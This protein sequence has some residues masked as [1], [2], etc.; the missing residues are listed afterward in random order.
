MQKIYKNKKR[1]GQNFL[2][3]KK[4][5][6]NIVNSIAIKKNDNMVEIGI[7]LGAITIPILE[8]IDILNIIEIDTDL[9]THWQK[10]QINNL[11]IHQ[12]D[13]LKFDF[14][15][16]GKDLRVVGNL[17]YNISTPILFKMLEN[18]DSIKDMLF[19]LQKEMVDRIVATNGN[20]TYG[21]ITVML[22]AFFD[23]QM[24]F[25]VP[26]FAFDPEPK[27]TSA[28]IYL[29][30]KKTKV[31]NIKN[32]EK[33]VKAAFSTRRKTLNNCLKK[34]ILQNDTK[35][36]LS[37]RAENLKIDDFII[38]SEDYGRLCNR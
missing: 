15:T 32:F 18:K 17:P 20:K 24:L 33:I 21:R 29:K 12:S 16:L 22:Q 10:L 30:P 14:T 4:I 31:K 1:F 27:V 19:M 13:V 37:L 34:L 9:I 11:V 5:I 2:V 28:V 38:L 3:D 36:D 23:V 8:K 25:S 35:I 6:D 26:N 7:G